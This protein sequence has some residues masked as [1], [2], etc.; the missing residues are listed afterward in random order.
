MSTRQWRIGLH[1]AESR[2]TQSRLLSELTQL[3]VSVQRDQL[4]RR[5]GAQPSH[6]RISA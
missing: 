4:R 3:S 5:S 2:I 1:C 6:P